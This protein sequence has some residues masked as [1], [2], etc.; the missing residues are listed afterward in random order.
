[1]VTGKTKTS[2]PLIDS[3]FKKENFNQYHLCL[4]IAQDH[5]SACVFDTVQDVVILAER[6]PLER[7]FVIEDLEAFLKHAHFLEEYEAV[8]YCWKGFPSVLVPI[9]LFDPEEAKNYFN[10]SHGYIPNQLDLIDA[11][12]CGVKIVAESIAKVDS[13]LQTRF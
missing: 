5:I 10:L 6:R 7:T 9:G 12:S 13:L 4:E 2:G 1:M 11:N 8:S 3:S